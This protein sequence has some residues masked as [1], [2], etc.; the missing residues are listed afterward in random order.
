M[1]ERGD[2]LKMGLLMGGGEA[3]YRSHL[4]KLKSV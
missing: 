2:E 1:V 3:R 4:K